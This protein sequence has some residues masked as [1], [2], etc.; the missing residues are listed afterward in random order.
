MNLCQRILI[1][2]DLQLPRGL[3]CAQIAHLHFE[4]MRQELLAH[5][6]VKEPL[7][8]EWIKDP[9]IFVHGVPNI[10]ALEHFRELAQSHEISWAEW[11]DTIYLTLYEGYTIPFEDI[12]IGAILGPEDSDRLKMVVGGLPLLK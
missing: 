4:A 11:T 8:K 7:T 9:Y 5:D 3:M 12:V 6:T 1:R 10:E 2:E